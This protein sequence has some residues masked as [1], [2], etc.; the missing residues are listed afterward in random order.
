VLEE[1][2]VA[3]DAAAAAAISGC[4]GGD[5]GLGGHGGEEGEGNGGIARFVQELKLRS[6]NVSYYSKEARSSY[7]ER[8][9]LHM[10]DRATFSTSLSALL[11]VS[12]T[13]W[14]KTK[15]RRSS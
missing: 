15:T 8:S 5:G 10:A 13:A 1:D 7:K 3:A 11:S 4:T 2:S 6:N 14:E 12:F 9:H